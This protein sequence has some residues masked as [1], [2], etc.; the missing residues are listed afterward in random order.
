MEQLSAS[1]SIQVSASDFPLWLNRMDTQIRRHI[2]SSCLNWKSYQFFLWR[3]MRKKHPVK[4]AKT[5][6][7]TKES[8]SVFLWE[9]LCCFLRF[10]GLGNFS[11]TMSTANCLADASAVT[12]YAGSLLCTFR[13][14]CLQGWAIIGMGQLFLLLIIIFYFCSSL[15]ACNLDL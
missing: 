1:T 15:E 13:L 4:I 3:T 11:V 14:C 7:K 2:P 5:N 6:F 12:V 8:R 10:C 9:V